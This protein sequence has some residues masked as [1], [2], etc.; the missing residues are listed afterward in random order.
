[1]LIQEVSSLRRE[2]DDLFLKQ[3][4]AVV[5]QQQQQQ[6]PTGTMASI[7]SLS[8][9]AVADSNSQAGA[10]A[11]PVAAPPP[12]QQHSTSTNQQH[13]AAD[14]TQLRQQHQP[15]EVLVLRAELSAARQ[16]ISALE[17]ELQ[18]TMDA[19]MQLWETVQVC[20]WGGWFVS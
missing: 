12:Q 4:Q 1:M 16:H 14:Q 10:A 18:D 3:W 7:A 8:V 6:P 17:A 20:M 5:V 9:D 19:A 13:T 11:P 15:D 2:N